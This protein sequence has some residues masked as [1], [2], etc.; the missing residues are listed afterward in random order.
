MLRKAVLALMLVLAGSAASAAVAAAP[1]VRIPTPQGF[2]PE[3]IAS[4][5]GNSLYVG[6]ISTGAVNRFNAKTG[7]NETAVAARAGYAAIGVEVDGKNIVVAG[8]PTGR[9]TVYDRTSG[10]LRAGSRNNDKDTF[11]NDI[12]RLG[13]NYWATDSRQPVLYRVKRNAREFAEVKLEGVPYDGEFNLNGIEAGR[14]ALIAVHSD[15][16]DLYRIDPVAAE[17]TKID[18]GGKKVKNGDGLLLEGRTLYVVQNQGKIAVVKLARDFESGRIKRTITS[19]DF[20]V[21]T[22]LTR[23][24][25]S[26]YAVNARFGTESPETAS[27]WVTRLGR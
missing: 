22:T 2:Q 11:I 3:G 8:G 7:V 1:D 19:S 18:L 17:G 16:G 13:G 24:N 27:Y 23:Q 4:G 5:P 12:A 14:G 15:D 20:D 25:G 10:E 21:P 6:S 9:V 26:L